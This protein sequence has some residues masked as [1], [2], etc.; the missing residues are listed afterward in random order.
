VRKIPFLAGRIAFGGFFL[1]NAINHFKH[2]NDLAQY[3]AAKNVPLPDLSVQFSGVVLGIGAV[4]LMLGLKPK[5]GAAAIAGFLAVA[6][7][8]M[9]DFWKA[10]DPQQRQNEMIQFMKN[11]ALLGA[12][13]ALASGVR[14]PWP[15]SV[16]EAHR[17]PVLERVRE[18]ARE[19]IAA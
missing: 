16:E 10:Q 11:M 4:S 14:E 13:L 15:L 9:H 2:K 7:P 19:K 8:I 1:Y 18:F 3:C 5:L 6:S 17:R 12:V